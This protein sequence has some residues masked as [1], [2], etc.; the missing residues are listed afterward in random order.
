MPYSANDP[1]TRWRRTAALI[2]PPEWTRPSGR[3]HGNVALLSGQQRLG[4]PRTALS[5]SG[6]WLR[7]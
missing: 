5:A 1:W 3:V 4:Q 2:R 6:F 7:L